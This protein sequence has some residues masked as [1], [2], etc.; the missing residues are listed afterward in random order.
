MTNFAISRYRDEQIEISEESSDH[1]LESRPKRS[2]HLEDFKLEESDLHS[3]D[4]RSEIWCRP[5][6]NPSSSQAASNEDLGPY[7]SMYEEGT[8][9][10]L[11]TQLLMGNEG[12]CSDSKEGYLWDPYYGGFHSSSFAADPFRSIQPETT[13]CDASSS[14]VLGHPV[15]PEMG[16]PKQQETANND[17]RSERKSQTGCFAQ[18]AWSGIMEGIPGSEWANLLAGGFASLI[19]V[20][21]KFFV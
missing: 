3:E 7:G 12:L 5:S 1:Q 19:S 21:I 20:T 4:A 18:D 10:E 15:F 9:S 14:V 11:Y 13:P 2:R 16:T 17:G 6:E 8:S